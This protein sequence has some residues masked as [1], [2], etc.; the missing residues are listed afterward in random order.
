MKVIVTGAT[1]FLGGWTLRHLRNRGIDAIGVSRSV[2]DPVRGI[3]QSSDWSELPRADVLLHFAESNNRFA[4]NQQGQSYFDTTVEQTKKLFHHGFSQLIYASS[5][6]VYDEGQAFS[7]SVREKLVP[8]DFYGHTKL[9]IEDLFLQ[10]GGTVLRV[11]NAYGTGMSP[12]NV[13]S[14]IMNQ[15]RTADLIELGSLDPIR[16]YV[17]G[18]DIALAFNI[19]AHKKLNNVYNIASGKGHSVRQVAEIIQKIANKN[20]PMK[21]RE[22]RPNSIII[23]DNQETLRD[24]SWIPETK[25]EDGLR[26]TFFSQ[27]S[28]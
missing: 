14:H 2:H 23:L 3:I 19:A 25:L 7:R 17:W 9:A 21:E 15:V 20:L 12:M 4:V 5:I 6:A 16:D 22:Y 24:F 1:G 28:P 8:P 13:I 26:S 27:G 18:G 11:A 10:K